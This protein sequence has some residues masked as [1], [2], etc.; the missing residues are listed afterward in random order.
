[1][2]RQDAVR[3]QTEPA[4]RLRETLLRK[5]LPCGRISVVGGTPTF[6]LH[7]R[8]DVPGPE[9]SPGTIIFC[10]ITV[11]AAASPMPGGVLNAGRSGFDARH[12]PANAVGVTFDIGTKAVAS[13]PPAGQRCLFARRARLSAGRPQRGASCGRDSRRLARLSGR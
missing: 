6:P 9:C 4:L 13:D 8:L 1:M 2:E 11:T 10:T 12:Q 7:V 3:S 5:G